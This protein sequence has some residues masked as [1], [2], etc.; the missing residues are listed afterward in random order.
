MKIRAIGELEDAIDH[1]TAWRK[2]ELTTILF[3]AQHERA[4]KRPTALRAGVAL[5][6]AH[7]EGWIKRV[8]SM[9]IDF[10]AQ[11]KLSY[12]ELSE[13]FLGLALKHKMVTQLAETDTARMH[14][15]FACFVR[16]EMASRA[17]FQS[18][19]LVKTEANVSSSVLREIVT[20]LGLDF[21]PYEMQ[22]KLID[23]RMLKRRNNVAHGE[24]LD[25]DLD[26]FETLHVEVVEMLRRF[27]GDVLADAG[28]G[29]YRKA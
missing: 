14:V 15:E 29:A 11:Q 23:Q 24:Y 5:L 2:R 3:T 27:T 6:Y 7:W 19:G 21:Q 8:A 17:R 28:R 18:K 26:E 10:V 16:E 25:L 12:Q 13:P 9:Y 4:S 1:E 22:A 20:R